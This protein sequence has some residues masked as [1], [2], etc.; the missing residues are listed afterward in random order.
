MHSAAL[1]FF[2]KYSQ[3]FLRIF[4]NLSLLDYSA[5]ATSLCNNSL[6]TAHSVNSSS[7][8]MLSRPLTRDNWLSW[9]GSERRAPVCPPHVQTT[10]CTLVQSTEWPQHRHNNR[11]WHL[12]WRVGFRNENSKG[13]I[14][15]HWQMPTR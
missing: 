7:L 1:L 4:I 14:H 9:P 12:S 8:K 5:Y 3:I 15:C 6:V 2:H 10:L 13:T 11:F